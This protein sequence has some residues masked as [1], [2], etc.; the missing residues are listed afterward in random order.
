MMAANRTT[1]WSS[2]VTISCRLFFCLV[3]VAM[4]IQVASAAVFQY[5]ATINSTKGER[6]AYL[7][8]PPAAKQ[9]RGVVIGGMT[10]A[11]R[12]LAQDPQIRRAC[13]DEQLAI[14]FLKCGLHE[15]DVPGVLESLAKVSGYRE[16][17]TA[18]LLIV[19]HSAGGP[20][21]RET[22]RKLADRCIAL[23]QYRGGCPGDEEPLPP[24]IPALMMIGQF[25]EFG[26]IGRDENGVD[27]WEKDRDK[28]AAYRAAD[29]RNLG[30]IVVEPGAGHYAWSDRNAHYLALFIRKA[31][32]ARIPAPSSDAAAVTMLEVP[33]ASGWLTDLTIKTPGQHK[34]AAYA[35]FKGDKTKAA[36][37]FDKEIALATVAYHAPMGRKDQFI[38]WTDAITIQAGA[39]N[40][41][42]EAKWVGDGQTFAV[43]PAYSD[44]YPVQIRGQGSRWGDAG[45]PVGKSSGPIRIKPV[46]G[47][48]VATGVHT[49]RIQ[50]DELAPATESAR[51]TFKA[52]SEGDE[53][54]RYTERVGM[55]ESDVIK[56]AQGKPQTI[57]FAPL[58]PL[59]A[60]S[61]PIELKATSDAGLPVEYHIAHGP[62]RIVDGRLIITELPARATYPLTVKVVAYQVG[63]GIE[64]RVQVAKPMEQTIQIAAAKPIPS[65]MPETEKPIAG[66]FRASMIESSPSLTSA[67]MVWWQGKLILADRVSKSL[68]AHTPP[69]K[70][71]TWKVLTHPVGV[72]VDPQGNLVVT[73]K[74]EGVINRLVRFTPQ[75][76]EETIAADE[77]NVGTPHFLTIHRNGT[78]YWSGFPDGGTRS[79][80]PNAS[81]KASDAAKVIIHQPRIVH[82]YGIGLSPQ[83]DSLYVASKIPNDKRGVWRFPV[84]AQGELGHGEF[85]INVLTMPVN[86]PALPESRDGAKTLAGWVGRLQGL[87]V[88]KHGYI[89]IAGAEMHHSGEAVAVIRPDGKEVV[90]MILDVPRNISGLAFGG[91]DGNT[92]YITGAGE[93]K[94]RQ[95]ELPVKGFFQT[96]ADQR[97]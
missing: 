92:L 40:F 13:A 79:L 50:H 15:V 11:E 2:G 64:P 26:K 31:A 93:Y 44:I 65:T 27:N 28:L 53:E 80:R 12:E 8:V 57:T 59:R 18:P 51:I 61:E 24:G 5:A 9:I 75:G 34:P 52:Y 84:D 89:Y 29:E 41:F 87:T 94:L 14:V 69:D 81:G 74:E 25:D 46:S 96:I 30:S 42:N 35:Q 4:Q 17:A 47:P 97:K 16:L 68:I 37:H 78:L 43:H 83:Q 49:F 7:W 39:R 33:P 95:V 60:D 55:F 73:E 1:A 45:R 62:A 76:K 82:T 19:G 71:E 72:A 88:D 91:K 10:L 23:V 86:L 85:F 21:A 70:F 90:A 36:W 6:M 38:R 48:L 3:L 32:K 66:I 63:R 20:Q 56:L 77:H 67:G 22:A 58:P 54:Y